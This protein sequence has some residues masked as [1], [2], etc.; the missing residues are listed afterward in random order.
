M[1][2]PRKVDQLPGVEPRKRGPSSKVKP[3]SLRPMPDEKAKWKAIA[4]G[5]GVSLHS[6]L[7]FLVRRGMCDIMR[8]RLTV[9]KE[10]VTSERIRMP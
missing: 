2:A 3:V 7:L 5:Q 8:G 1:P 9:P 10:T 6:L 4:E